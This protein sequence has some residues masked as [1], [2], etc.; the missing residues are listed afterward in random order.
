MNI[1]INFEKSIGQRLNRQ[2]LDNEQSFLMRIGNRE[3]GTGNRQQ[4]HP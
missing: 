4:F 1:W 2:D 3:Q